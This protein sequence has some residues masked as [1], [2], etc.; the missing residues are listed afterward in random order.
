MGFGVQDADL[1]AVFVDEDDHLWAYL[2]LLSH[3]SIIVVSI[4]EIHLSYNCAWGAIEHGD[5]CPR[6]ADPCHI[7]DSVAVLGSAA[8]IF[9]YTRATNNSSLALALTD[10]AVCAD[11]RWQSNFSSIAVLNHH[12]IL[13]LSDAAALPN[14]A[15]FLPT[16]LVAA[17][18]IEVSQMGR[19]GATEMVIMRGS[20]GEGGESQDKQSENHIYYRL[21]PDKS[22]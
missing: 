13:T 17:R 19:R 21:Y 11:I 15:T 7:S 20:C 8:S 14:M 2:D 18:T 1:L 4:S 6:R 12:N 9:D 10:T 5:L 3:Y 22:Y 16:V